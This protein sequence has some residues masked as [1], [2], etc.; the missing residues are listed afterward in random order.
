MHTSGL[1][2]FSLLQRNGPQGVFILG[3]KFRLGVSLAPRDGGGKWRWTI[4]GPCTSFLELKVAKFYNMHHGRTVAY[5][6][7]GAKW[8]L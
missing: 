7:H 4:L 1:G 3:L 6:P 2:K 5:K 8:P